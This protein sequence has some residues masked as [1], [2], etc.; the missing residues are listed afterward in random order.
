MSDA[1]TFTASC[2]CVC[3]HDGKSWR[4]TGPRCAVLD[5]LL[6]QHMRSQSG[7]DRARWMDHTK[8]AI[9]EAYQADRAAKHG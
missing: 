9:R 8:Q 6:E 5:G 4:D 7:A 2:G 1:R 3:S